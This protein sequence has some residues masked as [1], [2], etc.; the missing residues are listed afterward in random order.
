[1]KQEKKTKTSMKTSILNPGHTYSGRS[2][3]KTRSER[4][5]IPNEIAIRKLLSDGDSIQGGAPNRFTAPRDGVRPEFDIRT[6]W[7]DL[8]QE[9]E[10]I[11]AK[12]RAMRREASWNE[13]SE[14]GAVSTE[15]VGVQE[16]P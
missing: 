11:V 3:I 4:T 13:S 6:D 9:A 15:T 10:T 1:M 5:G 12:Q 14:E 7:Q 2:L 8:A 16:T